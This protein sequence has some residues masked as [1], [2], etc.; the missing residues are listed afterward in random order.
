MGQSEREGKGKMTKKQL[1]QLRK[2]DSEL[3]I[4]RRHLKELEE[5]IGISAAPSDG[6]PRG[7][8]IGRPTEQQAVAMA[9]TIEKIRVLEETIQIEKSN[10]WEYIT[11][12]SDSTIRQII[13]LRF[14]D[15]LSWFKVSEE[16]GGVATADWCRVTLERYFR[17]N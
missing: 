6:Q 16:I 12:I 5:S 14:I 8:K 2:Y 7:N 17:D 4:L 1:Q 3:H 15:G 13:I 10:T 9:D 11:K